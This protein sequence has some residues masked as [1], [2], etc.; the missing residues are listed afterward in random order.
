MDP[1]SIF[2][3]LTSVLTSAVQGAQALSD[4]LGSIKGAPE[5]IRNIS[6]DVAALHKLLVILEGFLKEN[7]VP[8][9]AASSLS[10]TV[11]NCMS[12]I[13]TT[14]DQ[15]KSYTKVGGDGKLTKWRSITWAFN[16]GSA[17]ELRD[18][19]LHHKMNLSISVDVING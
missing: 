6:Q 1:L 7:Q 18:R 3:G 4:L 12:A 15:I 16:R 13:D 14:Q 11:R 17:K 10:E 8:T 19:L 2:F 5:E 9:Y